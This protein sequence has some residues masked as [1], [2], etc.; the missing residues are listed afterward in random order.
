MM[1]EHKL[2]RHI[3]S[4]RNNVSSFSGISVCLV[5]N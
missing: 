1:C 5:T 2:L 4:H 3:I